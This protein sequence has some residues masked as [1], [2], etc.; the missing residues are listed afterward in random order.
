M[1]SASRACGWMCARVPAMCVSDAVKEN[2]GTI[3]K[4]APTTGG[5]W[6]TH[7]P[8]RLHEEKWEWDTGRSVDLRVDRGSSCPAS[9]CRSLNL[10]S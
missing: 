10:P 3:A 7:K 2:R 8:F 6:P 1:K 5:P 9:Q 4:R